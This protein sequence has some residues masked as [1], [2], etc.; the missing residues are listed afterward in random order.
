MNLDYKKIIS[1]RNPGM[2]MFLERGDIIVV[3]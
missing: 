1:G 3:D 2:N